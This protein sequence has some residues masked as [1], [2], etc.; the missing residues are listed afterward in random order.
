MSALHPTVLTPCQLG[1][2]SPGIA[3]LPFLFRG[4]IG[5]ICPAQLEHVVSLSNFC[6][7]EYSPVLAASPFHLLCSLGLPVLCITPSLQCL[8]VPGL[9][10][11]CI[12]EASSPAVLTVAL[13]ACLFWPGDRAEVGPSQELSSHSSQ[14]F[15]DAAAAW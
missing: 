2:S 12:V 10:L 5:V 7:R 4:F 11:W 15:L 8:N 3:A 6:P 13:S 1:G 14:D 9:L